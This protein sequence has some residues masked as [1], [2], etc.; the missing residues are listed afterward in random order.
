[1]MALKIL[2]FLGETMRKTDEEI[3]QEY[4]ELMCADQVGNIPEEVYKHWLNI[5]SA[6]RSE[7]PRINSGS[8]YIDWINICDDDDDFD[9]FY[10]DD[11]FKDEDT[12]LEPV[13][14]YDPHPGL[15]GCTV[16]IP[17]SVKL[18][19]NELNGTVATLNVAIQKIKDSLPI[20]IHSVFLVSVSFK[21]N[22]I[23][24]DEKREDGYENSWRVL[25]YRDK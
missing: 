11:Y 15:A 21:H 14:F 16:R 8:H 2:Q 5:V 19:A 20:D 1:M 3:L 17:E 24:L 6:A 22:M 25:R 7:E 9:T 10:G 4:F 18:V 23:T 13:E 12:G